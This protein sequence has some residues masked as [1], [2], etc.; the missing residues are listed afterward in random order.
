MHAWAYNFNNFSPATGF[1]KLNVAKV[2]R[3]NSGK[4]FHYLVLNPILAGKLSWKIL[5]INFLDSGGC[6]S[7]K[8]RFLTKPCSLNDKILVEMIKYHRVRRVKH[9]WCWESMWVLK[10]YTL[11]GPLFG[12]CTRCANPRCT[13]WG[14]VNLDRSR[15]EE[16][17]AINMTRDDPPCHQFRPNL[18]TLSLVHVPDFLVPQLEIGPLLPSWKCLW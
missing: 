1:P 18:L 2:G 12:A 15:R 16:A 10:P 17:T 14:R 11:G 3:G 13:K 4:N 5:C 6:N 7:R 9:R 8:G